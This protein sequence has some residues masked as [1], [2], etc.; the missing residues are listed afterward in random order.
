M[1]ILVVIRIQEG[2]SGF[3]LSLNVGFWKYS[4]FVFVCLCV[5]VH[6][7][8]NL[9]AENNSTRT[10][11]LV[12]RL[13]RTS[14]LMWQVCV[15][16]YCSCGGIVDV[17]IRREPQQTMQHDEDDKQYARTYERYGNTQY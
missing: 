13:N 4:T 8:I 17:A 3:F 1:Y 12:E 9:S 11:R 14:V 15:C 10:S 7:A 6:T 2:G 5:R 16:M